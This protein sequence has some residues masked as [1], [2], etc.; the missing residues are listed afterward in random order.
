MSANP[1]ESLASVGDRVGDGAAMAMSIASTVMKEIGCGPGDNSFNEAWKA[2]TV[3]G[4]VNNFLH[5][6]IFGDSKSKV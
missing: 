3:P 1:L 2:M 5:N 4:P 6:V